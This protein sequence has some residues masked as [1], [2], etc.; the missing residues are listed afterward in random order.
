MADT[1]RIQQ[2]SIQHVLIHICTLQVFVTEHTSKNTVISSFY[3][4][5]TI[6]TSN[7]SKLTSFPSMEIEGKGHPLLCWQ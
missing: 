1:R 4:K 7:T 5:M 6:S 2:Q 3:Y